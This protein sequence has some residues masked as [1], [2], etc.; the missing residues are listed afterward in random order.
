MNSQSDG[1]RRS[2]RVILKPTIL[3]INHMH[4]L[5]PLFASKDYSM[6][7]PGGQKPT[8]RHPEYRQQDL[9]QGKK[10]DHVG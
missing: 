9:R 6:T 1:S 3:P 2:F 4:A 5:K 10:A 8:V 7:Y